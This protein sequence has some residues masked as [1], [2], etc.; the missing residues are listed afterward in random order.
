MEEQIKMKKHLK[1]FRMLPG[2]AVILL[3]IALLT[4]A[5]FAQDADFAENLNEEEASEQIVEAPEAPIFIETEPMSGLETFARRL[6][7]GYLVN[8]FIEGGWCMWPMIVLAIWGVAMLIWKLVAL[9]YAKT[10]LNAF[11]NHIL[12]LIRDKKYRE[13]SDFANNARGPVASIAYAAILKANTSTEA[14]EKAIE[15]SATIEMAFL[16]KGFIAI[17]TTITLA[18]MFG[19]FGTILGMIEA[20]DAIARAGEV[21]PTIVADGIKIA[22][23]TTMFGLAI[24]IPVQFINN[25]LLQMVD[26]IVLDMQRASDKIIETIVDNK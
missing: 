1:A 6:V 2:L 11:L 10:N 7:G 13:A 17:N 12:P 5:L 16:E 3:A 20:F 8:L 23:I 19:F 21:D 4:S 14:V 22:L 9:S 15:N 24:A 26:G 25:V 18:P